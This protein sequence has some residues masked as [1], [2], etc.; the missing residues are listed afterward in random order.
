MTPISL[1]LGQID[2]LDQSIADTSDLLDRVGRMQTPI[3]DLLRRVRG[4][5]SNDLLGLQ[6]SCAEIRARARGGNAAENDLGNLAQLE[7]KVLD[8]LREC[9]AFLEGASTRAA[10]ID[11]GICQIADAMLY[12]LSRSNDLGWERFTLVAVGEFIS[13][14][15]GIV[16]LRFTDT[17]IW[18]LPVAAHEFGHY[19]SG[20]PAFSDFQDAATAAKRLDSRYDAH[21]G[22]LFSDLFATYVM[23]PCY[24]LNCALLRFGLSNAAQESNTHPSN[25]QRVWWM[26]ETLAKMDDRAW[27]LYK[28][29]LTQVKGVWADAVEAAKLGPLT[30]AETTR[31]RR[32]LQDLYDLLDS[33]LPNAKYGKWLRAQEIS[34]SLR[35][36][37]APQLRPDDSIPDVLNGAWLYRLQAADANGFALNQAAKTALDLCTA[38][39]NGPL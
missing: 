15:S 27:P 6:K 35:D 32:W 12:Q 21:L 26:M 23:G 24:L 36:N 11:G 9:L 17:R 5:F 10:G 8:T 28:D 14:R 25:A 33:R 22:E 37:K 4:R 34:Q 2:A 19:V 1:F 39:G 38:I 13:A 3:S 18:N 30:D 20:L 29:L 16:R 7:R 31:L